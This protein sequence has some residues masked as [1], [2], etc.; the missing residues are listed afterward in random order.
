MQWRI[1]GMAGM[2]CSMGCF[3]MHKGLLII[4]LLILVTMTESDF[5]IN[6]K[7][8]AIKSIINILASPYRIININYS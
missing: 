7:F 6:Q 4:E 1:Y 8:I 5:I 3:S 2:A